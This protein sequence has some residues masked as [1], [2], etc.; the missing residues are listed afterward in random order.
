M[1]ISVKD[2]NSGKRRRGSFNL[3]GNFEVKIEGPLDTRMVVGSITDLLDTV[4]IENEPKYQYYGM[5]V[6]VSGDDNPENDGLYRLLE[7][8][9]PTDISAWEKIGSGSSGP[10]DDLITHTGDT[11]NPHKTS[12]SNLTSTA[13]THTIADITD[14]QTQLEDKLNTSDFDAY[15]G[16]V[17]T[18]LSGKLD[19]SDFTSHTGDTTIHYTK[20]S[21]NLSDLGSTAH[22]H[23][24]TDI[25]DLQSELDSKLNTSDFDTYSGSVKTQ[26][27]S[28][29]DIDTFV[30]YTGSVKDVHVTSGSVNA[31]DQS[32]TFTDTSGGT[33]DLENAASLFTDTDSYV[34]GGTYNPNT[35]VVTYKTS[36]GYT[37][38]VTGYF[39]RHNIKINKK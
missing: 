24:I 30:E 33:F 3:P 6:V 4:N 8:G 39:R 36:S 31:Q 20:D 18:Q 35:G 25:T 22:T 29:L 7:D 26:L 28:K 37:F 38:E 1:A 21:I 32:I 15:S 34:T 17:Q 23:S 10:S 5:L 19:N 12:F 2:S 9:D 16:N 27:D 13:H 14:L 11:N